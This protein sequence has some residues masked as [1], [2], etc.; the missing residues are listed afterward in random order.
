M[1]MVTRR[2]L[3]AQ[4]PYQ[5]FRQQITQF[6]QITKVASGRFVE[7]L[8]IARKFLEQVKHDGTSR[9]I[10]FVHMRRTCFKLC[11]ELCKDDVIK[12]QLN[13]MACVGHGSGFDGMQWKGEQEVVIT[14]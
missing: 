2:L 14:R 11:E 6:A 3:L 7:L 5:T 10:V 4:P 1:D 13:P 12:E 9:A 8:S